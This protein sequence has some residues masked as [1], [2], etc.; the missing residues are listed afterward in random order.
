MLIL[1]FT[2]LLLDAQWKQ[3]QSVDTPGVFDGKST[4]FNDLLNLLC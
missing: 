4:F 2:V 1:N 3:M